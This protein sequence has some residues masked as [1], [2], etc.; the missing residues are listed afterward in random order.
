MSWT[1]PRT[2]IAN[3]VVT[4]AQMNTHVRDNFNEVRAGGLSLPSQAANDFIYASTST[5][6]GRIGVAGPGGS[7]RVP[8]WNTPNW[9]LVEVYPVG[10][11]LELTVSTNPATLFGFGTWVAFGEGRVTVCIDAAQSEFNA[12]GETGG[13]KTHILTVAELAA[14]VHDFNTFTTGTGG[15]VTVTNGANNSGGNTVNLGGVQ[16]T[17]GDVGHNNLQ[18]Y[19]VVYRWTRTA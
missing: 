18:P 11:I 16:S 6:L 10:I 15:V 12:N 8:M 2:W 19:I 4:A 5:Q 17:G 3:E 14:H 7:G 1:T 13:E 9:A